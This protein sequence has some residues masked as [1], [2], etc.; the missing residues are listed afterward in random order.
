MGLFAFVVAEDGNPV[1]KRLGLQ[2]PLIYAL[3]RV[4]LSMGLFMWERVMIT[5]AL[6]G[7]VG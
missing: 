5:L 1:T 2:G 6:A 4:N 3:V 7:I